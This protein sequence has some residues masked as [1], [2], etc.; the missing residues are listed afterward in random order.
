MDKRSLAEG[1]ELGS[2]SQWSVWVSDMAGEAARVA[3]EDAGAAEIQ[4]RSSGFP[5]PMQRFIVS[6]HH[7][8]KPKTFDRMK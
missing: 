8:A 5:L 1:R 3:V 4:M 6:T 7:V 2:S